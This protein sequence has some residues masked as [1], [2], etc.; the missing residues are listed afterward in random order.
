MCIRDSPRNCDFGSAR[1][2]REYIHS[3]YNVWESLGISATYHHFT[4]LKISLILIFEGAAEFLRHAVTKRAAE[5][6]WHVVTMGAAEFLQHTVTNGAAEFLWSQ[7]E[8]QNF[9]GM[10]WPMRLKNFCGLWFQRGCRI[11]AA[12]SHKWGCRISAPPIYMG[13]RDALGWRRNNII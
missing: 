1:E 11:S 8:L 13:S 6:L 9:C 12:F 3:I 2:E 7:W 10:Q 4:W 5:F